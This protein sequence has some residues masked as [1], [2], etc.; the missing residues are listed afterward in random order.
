DGMQFIL[1]RSGSEIWATW[2]DPM[3]A[4]DA[5]SYLLGPVFGLVLRLRGFFTLHA[6]VVCIGDV[7]I[8]V[9]GSPGAGKS[10]TAAA[11]A[12]HGCPVLSDDIA[13]LREL[14]GDILVQPAYPQLNLWPSSVE[15]LYGAKDRLPPIAPNWDKRYL[16]LRTNGYR[17]H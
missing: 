3:C 12:H 16:D 2:P 5:V 17:F 15:A 6:S 11:L 10:T 9:A 7:A 8:A 14:D 1:D 13:A 4:E